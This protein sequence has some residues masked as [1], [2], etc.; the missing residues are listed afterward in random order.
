MSAGYRIPSFEHDS[1][2]TQV[3]NT[4][5]DN[6]DTLLAEERDSFS[7][8]T[9]REIFNVNETERSARK[10]VRYLLKSLFEREQDLLMRIVNH[11]ITIWIFKV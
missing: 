8:R 9:K 3:D 10:K 11:L 2:S 7:L 6:D 1:S 4:K 5:N